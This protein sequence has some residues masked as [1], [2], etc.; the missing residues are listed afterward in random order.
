MDLPWHLFG[1]DG[2]GYRTL[3]ASDGV[4]EGLARPLERFT[5]GQSNDPGYL[6]ALAVAPAF[7]I[8]PVPG[9]REVVA[10]TRILRGPTDADGRPSLRFATLLASA[11]EWSDRLA[12]VWHPI[13]TDA[14]RWELRA[15]RGPIGV[16]VDP[17]LPDDPGL[18]QPAVRRALEA[19]RATPDATV[20]APPGML[21]L[22]HVCRFLQELPPAERA[23]M[24][25][26]FGALTDGLKVRL[27]CL[28]PEHTSVQVSH[29]RVFLQPDGR[30]EE[31]P[32]V[33]RRD[34]SPSPLP[35][36][37]RRHPASAP[38]IV[39]AVPRRTVVPK[40]ASLMHRAILVLLAV[41]LLLQCVFGLGVGNT[42][43]ANAEEEARRSEQWRMDLENRIDKQGAAQDE[44]EERLHRLL[45]EGGKDS[46][47][48][49]ARSG[50]SIDGLSRRLTDEL[51]GIR[52]LLE[53]CRRDLIE[54]RKGVGELHEAG[55]TRMERSIHSALGKLEPRLA[56]LEEAVRKEKESKGGGSVSPGSEKV[57]WDAILDKAKEVFNALPGTDKKGRAKM[58]ELVKLLEKARSESSPGSGSSPNSKSGTGS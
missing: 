21:D 30:W 39:D 17:G 9:R 42:L 20:V 37:R 27:L 26:A 7:W 36:A 44:R 29:R 55:A 25:L 35:T 4:D 2:A 51:N 32:A 47:E 3:A 52:E 6:D 23:G 18:V 57:N 24:T 5:W 31:P 1:S 56:S 45:V 8:E 58:D 40:E 28:A 50:N 13:V 34:A 19:I 16:N 54:V 11:G 15:G 10:L 33:A 22:G 41:L 48:G 43:R 14:S 12:P 38:P 53:T 49:L 46:R